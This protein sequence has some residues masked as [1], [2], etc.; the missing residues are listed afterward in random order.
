M[1]TE[2]RDRVVNAL[3]GKPVTI[4]EI[5]Q[6]SESKWRFIYRRP[7]GDCDWASAYERDRDLLVSCGFPQEYWE[8]SH[9][10]PRECQP[11]V[12]MNFSDQYG[13]RIE[14]AFVPDFGYF[15]WHNHT[16]GKLM[17]ELAKSSAEVARSIQNTVNKKIDELRKARREQR[18]AEGRENPEG[19]ELQKEEAQILLEAIYWTDD[20]QAKFGQIML[21]MMWEMRQSMLYVQLGAENITE[22]I[23]NNRSSFKNPSYAEDMARICDRIF[24]EVQ[25]LYKRNTPFLNP[26]NNEAITVDTLIASPG[27]IRKLKESSDHYS[28][29][30]SSDDK[31]DL[32]SAIVTQSSTKLDA[33][34]QK[35]QQITVAT[36]LVMRFEDIEG[37]EDKSRLV[38]EADHPTLQAVI[39]LLKPLGDFKA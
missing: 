20:Q 8:G 34:R 35:Q 30:I 39:K 26:D 33:T 27:L 19:T 7:D 2:Q 21:R 36:Q 16:K 25:A 31:R 28:K 32:M 23:R 18:E 15:V 13:W 24:P 3:L 22:L 5:D 6:V 10:I 14:S 9:R 11:M 4:T 37:D 1:L 38:I 29:L 17:S 12:L